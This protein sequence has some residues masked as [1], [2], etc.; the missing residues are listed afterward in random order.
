MQALGIN[1]SAVLPEVLLVLLAM[2]V[3]MVDAFAG[4]EEN[5]AKNAIPWISL[6]G[7]VGIIFFAL[8]QWGVAPIYFQSAAVT[9]HFTIGL[10]LIVLVT[11]GLSIL[12]SHT[13]IPR[14]NKQTGEYYALLLLCTAGMMMMGAAV[15]LMV[16]FLS[17]EIFSLGLYI[18]TGLHR[19]NVRGSEAALK[20][21]L[22]GAFASAFFVYG[23]ALIYGGT[24]S[25]NYA[26]IGRAHV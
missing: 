14:I 19:Q 11:T 5:A 3:M 2:L 15:D 23:A 24:G 25:T 22:L 17:L 4:K 6:I 1:I 12:V 16:V 9:D 18:L 13:Y 26:Q 7:V 21:F 10:R 20:Y 8:G